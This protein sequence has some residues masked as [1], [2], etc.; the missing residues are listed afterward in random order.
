MNDYRNDRM[1]APQRLSDMAV[2][3]GDWVLP[4]WMGADTV[5]IPMEGGC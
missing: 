4:D 1:A 2:L 3:Y 5:L